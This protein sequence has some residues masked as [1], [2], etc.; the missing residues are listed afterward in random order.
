[1][2][3]QTRGWFA[4]PILVRLVIGIVVGL[5]YF[6]LLL[7]LSVVLAGAGHGIIFPFALSSPFAVGGLVTWPLVGALLAVGGRA[8][9][10]VKFMLALHYAASLAYFVLSPARDIRPDYANPFLWLFG[11]VFVL[12][13]VLIWIVAVKYSKRDIGI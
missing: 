4:V 3:R 8:T 5:V 9:G 10:A 12:G 2:R 13:Q 11:F 6:V 1:M 7:A